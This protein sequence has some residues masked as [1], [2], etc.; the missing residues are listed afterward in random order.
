M[1]LQSCKEMTSYAEKLEKQ[2]VARDSKRQDEIPPGAGPSG[3][4][5]NLFPVKP[6][7]QVLNRL[8]ER[9]AEKSSKGVDTSQDSTTIK[10]SGSK[11]QN[12][13]Q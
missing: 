1:R 6:G 13:D 9:N 11:D 3:F 5:R 8:A 4:E 7:R 10:E 2:R 12:T